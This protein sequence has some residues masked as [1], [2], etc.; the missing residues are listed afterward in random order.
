M[1]DSRCHADILTA[2]TFN[3]LFDRP[4]PHVDLKRVCMHASP[5]LCM[6]PVACTRSYAEKKNCVQG[7]SRYRSSAEASER[8]KECMIESQW[9]RQDETWTSFFHRQILCCFFWPK[10]TCASKAVNED[11]SLPRF[12]EIF[13]HLQW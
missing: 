10:H 4:T 12:G 8:G 11:S 6:H 3:N 7:G 5:M 13:F 9:R 1:T 2:S